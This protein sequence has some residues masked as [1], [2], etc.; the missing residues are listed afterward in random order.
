MNISITISV[1]LSEIPGDVTKHLS[2]TY[3]IPVF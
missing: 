3:Q 1:K 2:I